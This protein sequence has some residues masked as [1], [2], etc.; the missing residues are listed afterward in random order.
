M[1]SGEHIR[2]FMHL[3]DNLNLFRRFKL[4]WGGDIE[5]SY[6]LLNS[7]PLFVHRK[8]RIVVYVLR[9]RFPLLILSGGGKKG[10]TGTSNRS[11]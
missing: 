10:N 8:D 2:L 7:F 5:F 3:S 6:L 11:W 9:D 4:F 1:Q